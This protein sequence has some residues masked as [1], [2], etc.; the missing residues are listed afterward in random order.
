MTCYLWNRPLDLDAEKYLVYTTQGAHCKL[1]QDQEVA[2][3]GWKR[4]FNK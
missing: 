1:N 4:D 3:Q 2:V